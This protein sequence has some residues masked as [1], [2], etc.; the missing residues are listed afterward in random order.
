MRRI[1]SLSFALLLTFLLA[2]C[3]S[4]EERAEEHYQSALSL[5][6]E[7]DVDR[8]IVELRSVFPL[9]ANHQEAR[10]TLAR[11]LLEDKGRPQAAY[12]QYLL[13]VEQYPDDIEARIHLSEIAYFSGN[14][15]EMIRHGT[16]A[17][18]LAPED[19]RVKA[20]ATALDYRQAIED[21]DG[22]ARR[23]L[24]NEAAAL[25]DTQD[26]S[27][28]LRDIGLD[29]A[30]ND[31]EFS[32]ALTLLDGIVA[33]YPNEKRYRNQRLQVLIELDDQDAI[34]TQLLDTIAQFP[35]D[36]SE[37]QLLIRYYLSRNELDKTETFLRDLVAA[38][39]ADDSTARID[40]I[41][42]LTELRDP[43][44]ARAEIEVAIA[45]E[46]DPALFIMLG[47]ALDFS[48]G[49]TETAIN[50][51][52]TAI[53]G[54]EPSTQTS[55]M[56][57]TLAQMLLSTNNEVGARALVEE[58]LLETPS[59]VGALKMNAAWLIDADDTD[60][61]I[62]SLRSALDTAP[63]DPTALT[64]MANA[65]TRTGS[66][67]LAR[68]FLA[69]AVEASG[70]AP[71]E[72]VRYAQ[73]LMSEERYLPAEDVLLPA[74]R[75]APDNLDLLQLTGRLYLA[76]DDTGR[77]QQVIA[78]LRGLETEQADGLAVGLEAQLVNQNNGV[79][80]ALQFLETVVAGNDA[81]IGSRVLLLR[82]QLSVGDIDKAVAT[83]QGLLAD[84]PDSPPLRTVL[85]TTLAVSGDLQGALQIYRDLVEEFPDQ[86]DL[87]VQIAALQ[88]RAG[89][90]TAARATIM[91][92]LADAP[93]EPRLQWAAASYRERDGDIDGAIDI[94]EQMYEANSNNIVVANNLA[95]LIGTYR[96]DEENL[97][98]AWVIARRFRD[99]DQPAIQDTYGWI[100]HRRG[101]SVDALPYLQVAAS[102]LTD[103]LI[104]QF[105]LAEVLFALDRQEEAFAQ[106]R[107]V[108][109]NAGIADTRPQIDIARARIAEIENAAPPASE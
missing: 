19:T 84:H 98:R 59:H 12:S 27:R 92:A 13:I 60:A 29:G 34:E 17:R 89:D 18:E 64:L 21:E 52:E 58:T 65:Y 2:A 97:Q 10:R 72:T 87:W 88:E 47:A 37:K 70:N 45:N 105:H 93:D 71:A 40:L 49:D 1:L 16:K 48:A 101:D 78:T 79:D 73:V 63:E 85:A 23:A 14:W 91:S 35:D 46:P 9:V 55:D 68:D 67:D 7:G 5:L 95:S 11:V 81:D 77:A 75:I 102:A 62:T 3:D 15:D 94:Y 61:A 74:I 44:A 22:P 41:R 86:P 28:I 99:A 38:S 32:R 53:E 26:P 6:D 36:A 24:V 43:E 25:L 96:D 69:L 109:D 107:I 82:A 20:I 80:D 106:Y 108:L 57:T 42:F 76:M 31:R 51:L 90:P 100:T 30:L 104:V 33:D 50:T 103:D 56:K 4:A 39:P 66:T 83:A 54:A 8:A